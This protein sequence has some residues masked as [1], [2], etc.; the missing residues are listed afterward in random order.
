[1]FSGGAA[2][3]LLILIY[4]TGSVSSSFFDELS[5]LLNCVS[6]RAH[7]VFLTGDLNIHVEC[8]NDLHAST[9]VSV[10]S[11]YGFSCRVDSPTHD[12]GGTLDVLFS[13]SDLAPV[14]VQVSDPGI[15]DHYLLTW[16]VN[17]N[18]PPSVYHS[19]L[20]RKWKCLDKSEFH[21]ALSTS[22]LCNF[23]SWRDMDPDP[24][25][26]SFDFTMTS[27]IDRLLP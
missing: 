1:M 10:L 2:S 4:R 24:L 9:L 11:S 6:T 7:P 12:A 19:V 26:A 14:S 25:A 5:Q 15:S 23:E 18:K 8:T 16:R 27:I 17:V 13:R 20:Y 21:H 3:Y 22:S